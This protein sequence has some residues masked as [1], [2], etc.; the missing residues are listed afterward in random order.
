[1]AFSKGNKSVAN[2][3]FTRYIGIASVGVKAV[4][5]TKE[6]HEEL[7]NTS[8]EEAPSYVTIFN[9]DNGKE[10]KT[11][12][13][14]LVLQPNSAVNKIEMPLIT[15]SLFISNKPRMGATSGK[16][17]VIDKYGRTAWVTKEEFKNKTIPMYANGPAKISNDYR[18]AYIGEAELIEFVREFLCIA[19]PEVWDN[20]AQQ[21]VANPNLEQDC[22]CCF[23]NLDKIF[24]G[25][26]TEI[27]ETLGLMPTNTCKVLLGVRTDLETGKMYQS[28]Y[29]RKFVRESGRNKEFV[30]EVTSMIE[31]A[32]ATGRT[33]NTE[34]EAVPVHEYVTTPTVITP[35]NFETSSEG[36]DLPFDSDSSNSLPWE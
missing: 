30:R 18:P 3:S 16:V 15:M 14:Q 20:N 28:V 32:N 25:D 12:R 19:K 21:W 10:V 24:E 6:E 8:L 33:L 1:M 13:I 11:A 23:E 22:V 26:F 4:N 9:D 5:P 31:N 7:F 34:Y 35:T 27:K 36:S 29:T 2:N 17:Q